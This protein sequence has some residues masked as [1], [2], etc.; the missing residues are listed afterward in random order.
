MNYTVKMRELRE[1]HDY[2][3]QKVAKFLNITT[4]QYSL[5]ETGK[6]KLPIDL[7]IKLCEFYQV[8]ADYMLV[9][10]DGLPYPKR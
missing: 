2:T 7:L 10:P 5:Y 1:D 6:R 8:S 4:Q 9:L 3:Q